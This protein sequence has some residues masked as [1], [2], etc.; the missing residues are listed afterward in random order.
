MP[1]Y[2]QPYMPYGMPNYNPYNQPAYGQPQVQQNNNYYSIVNGLDGAKSFQVMPN[3]TMLLMDSDKP[4]V[5]KKS[6]N[7][8]GQATIE[9]FKLVGITEQ[10]LMNFLTM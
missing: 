7:G 8:L 1:N 5:Y 9:C 4:I 3:Q 6:A 2:N 10:F